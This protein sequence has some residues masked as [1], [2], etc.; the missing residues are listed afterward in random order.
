MTTVTGTS[1][2]DSWNLVGPG[3]V[4]LDGLGGTDTLYMGTSLRSSY[5]ITQSTDGAVHVDTISGASSAFHGTLLNMEKLVFNNGQD[6]L[7]LTTYFGDTSPPVVVSY[8]PAAQAAGVATG[9]NIVLTFSEPIQR[10]TGSIT[11]A[12]ASGATV[13]TY[14]AATSGNLS[15][16]GSTLT[17]NPT[18]DL[19]YGTGYKIQFAAGSIKDFA[20]NSYAGTS[21]YSFTTVA[22]LTATG[23]AGNDILT[24]SPGN[25]TIDGGGGIDTVK[26]SSISVNFAISHNTDGSYTVKDNVGTDGTD[27]LTNVERLQFSDKKLALDT[28]VTQSAGETA[29]LLGAV[30][31]GTLAFEASK[32]ALLGSVIGLFDAGYTLKDLSGAVLRLPIWDVLTGKATPTNIDIANYLLTNVNNGQAPDQAT[33]DAAVKALNTEPFGD[34]LAILAASAANQTHVNLVGLQQAGMQYA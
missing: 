23:T 22:G 20:G 21:A 8:S 29:L 7:D 25:D 31:R 24:G 10:G 11:I 5:T 33:L 12:T 26:Y 34:W 17:I 1:G 19:G 4:T 18:S 3:T 16:S 32:E 14:D 27:T 2:N 28:G 30:L 6:T 15:I 13:A 9:S